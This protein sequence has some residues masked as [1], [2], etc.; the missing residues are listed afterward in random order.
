MNIYYLEILNKMVGYCLALWDCKRF[1]TFP[2]CQDETL[3]IFKITDT[4]LIDEF[5]QSILDLLPPDEFY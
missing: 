3:Q 2:E 5:Y 1:D 4:V